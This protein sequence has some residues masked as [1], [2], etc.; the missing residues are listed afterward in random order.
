MDVIQSY[1]EAGVQL[2]T[3]ARYKELA[4]ARDA[5]MQD[6]ALQDKLG[7]FNL[8]RLDLSNEMEK[9]DRDNERV[10]QLNKRL[11][12]L[13]DDIMS[14]KKMVAYNEAKENIRGLIN[15]IQAILSAAV[16]GEDPM[17]VEEPVASCGADGCASCSGCG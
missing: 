16:E 12:S 14:D 5:Y 13:Y 17:L 10:Q 11:N 2:Q 6:A 9:G 15:H 7:E 8:V 4:A 3:D 1:K